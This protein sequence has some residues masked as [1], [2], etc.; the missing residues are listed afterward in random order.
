MKEGTLLVC[1][2]QNEK[3]MKP[4]KQ[5]DAYKLDNLDEVTLPIERH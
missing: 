4:Y 5:I 2:Y 1:G 3:R